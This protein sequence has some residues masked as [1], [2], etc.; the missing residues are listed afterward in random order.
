MLTRQAAESLCMNGRALNE[1]S[2]EVSPSSNKVLE[3]TQETL[4]PF[5]PSKNRPR[6]GDWTCPSCGFSN[7]QRRT[8]CFRCSY[9]AMQAA[10]P[11]EM[12]MGFSYGFPP[13]PPPMMPH[14]GNHNTAGTITNRL[15][16]SAPFR[17]GDW[18]CGSQDCLYHNFAK[19]QTCLRC[20]SSRADALVISEGPTMNFNAH[21]N[22]GIPPHAQQQGP[23]GGPPSMGGQ[24]GFQGNQGGFQAN[25]GSFGPPAGGFGPPP[26]AYGVPGGLDGQ[27]Y[28]FP[29]PNGM[30]P[31]GFERAQ[32][33]FTSAGANPPGALGAPP[34]MGI[35]ANGGAA[36]FDAPDPFSFL[37]GGS[38]GS[39]SID[40]ARRNGAGPPGKNQA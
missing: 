6:P 14:F 8:A 22:F 12:N 13:A 26:S 18:R 36:G 40:D 1:K 3:R 23:P 21:P 38:F 32:A 37:G 30:P 11:S 39:L 27:N 19:N 2:I 17:P 31:A 20:G 24:G 7:F 15:G 35:L 9:P 28:G 16:A 29:P 4:A 5:P 25:Q 33:A 34:G 10:P